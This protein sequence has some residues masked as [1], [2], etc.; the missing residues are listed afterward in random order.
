MNLDLGYNGHRARRKLL[1]ARGCDPLEEQLNTLAEALDDK[2]KHYDGYRTLMFVVFA[3]CFIL[4]TL[5]LFVSFFSTSNGEQTGLDTTA[6]IVFAQVLLIS[7][8]SLTIV[9][10]AKVRAEAASYINKSRVKCGEIYLRLEETN[11]GIAALLEKVREAPES[12]FINRRS[13]DMAQG[14]AALAT[15]IGELKDHA[16]PRGE[17]PR[18]FT[19]ADLELFYRLISLHDEGDYVGAV[20]RIGELVAENRSLRGQ[21]TFAMDEV[22]LLITEAKKERITGTRI[23]ACVF[24]SVIALAISVI[25]LLLYSF[26]L[27]ADFATSVK[28][29]SFFNMIT[30]V[31]CVSV[32]ATYALIGKR[33]SG[34]QEFVSTLKSLSDTVNVLSKPLTTIQSYRKYSHSLDAAPTVEKKK[35]AAKKGASASAADPIL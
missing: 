17:A 26:G 30:F 4:L 11:D 23:A 29:L 7:I 2:H 32:C 22:V 21:L 31:A 8:I 9:N 12:W 15:V 5:S 6:I 19:S 24:F 3:L 25:H 14:F 20:A 1:D 18:W 16:G 33:T 27:G 10:S 28:G 35:G 34:E 13:E